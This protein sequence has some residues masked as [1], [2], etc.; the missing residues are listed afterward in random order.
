MTPETVKF[1]TARLGEQWYAVEVAQVIEVLHMVEFTPIPASNESLLGVIT[2]RN[3][4]MPLID[5]RLRFGLK[6]AP[7]KLDTPIIAIRDGSGPMGLIFDDV[8]QIEEIDE[9]QL[10]SPDEAHRY[11]YIRAVAKL[12]GR[13]LFILDTNRIGTESQ[14]EVAAIKPAASHT[15]SKR[16]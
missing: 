8:D 4:V 14:V 6:D 16:K 1:L 10:T 11:T 15:K 2:V 12:P 3:V 7:L 9:A 5:L 13:L